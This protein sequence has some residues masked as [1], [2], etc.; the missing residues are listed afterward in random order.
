MVPQI[1]EL[2]FDLLSSSSSDYCLLLVELAESPAHLRGVGQIFPDGYNMR[3]SVCYAISINRESWNHIQD[4]GNDLT[5]MRMLHHF[6]ESSIGNSNYTCSKTQFLVRRRWMFGCLRKSQCGK[7][8]L[9]DVR[10]E[11]LEPQLGGTL[12]GAIG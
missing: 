10:L 2:H 7:C 4:V 8:D 9:I 6:Y 5:R 1:N 3:L 12:G 11:A